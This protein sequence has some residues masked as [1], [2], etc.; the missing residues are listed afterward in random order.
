MN[1]TKTVTGA[2]VHVT[3]ADEAP[4]VRC[5][6]DITPQ[7]SGTGTPSPENVRPISGWDEVETAVSGK[8]LLKNER[9]TVTL[10]GVT[11][12]VNEDK[13]VTANGTATQNVYFLLNT[14]RKIEAKAGVTY[15]L[16]GC[17]SGGSSGYIIYNDSHGMSD[18]G[19]G[20][21]YTPTADDEWDFFIRIVNGTAVNNVLFKPML[22]V[23][24]TGDNDEYEPYNGTI[25]TTTLGRT[26]YGGTLD[27]VSGELKVTHGFIDLGTLNWSLYNGKF[28]A[29]LPLSKRY[30]PNATINALCSN[31][32]V[33][34]AQSSVGHDVDKSLWIS[35]SATPELYVQDSTYADAASFKTAMSGV[36]L[37]YEL[38]TPQTYTLTGQ[39]V[40]A[41]YGE[42]YIWANSGDIEIT[43]HTDTLGIY[44]KIYINGRPYFRPNDFEIKRED[45]YAGEYTT[46]TGK[47]IADKIGWKYSDLPM[48]WDILP[49]EDLVY[50]TTLTGS[51]DITFRDSD[52]QHT[53]QVIR[54]AFTNT[55]TRTTGPE[56][57]KIWTG[58]EMEVSF[59]N[60][61]PI[62]E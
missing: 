29:A 57:T 61:H 11:F 44:N 25:N 59:L 47:L 13:S 46:C 41:M 27:V 50:L 58:V 20:S 33:Y 54:R 15:R 56:G 45:V 7:Q 60:T 49:D 53:E 48:K 14:S 30:S 24:Q 34:P 39:E 35:Y 16:T 5:L 6:V 10:G 62:G 37:G 21:T 28:V 19:S 42:N 2:I 3:D 52:G 32:P 31:Y 51:F 9:T 43:Y 38:A 55:P 23:K 22:R 40:S 36:Q 1:D 17:P 18:S 26:V 8:N 4:L 12:T